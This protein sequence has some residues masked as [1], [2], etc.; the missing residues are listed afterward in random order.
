[1][2]RRE[3][4]PLPLISRR[5]F[6]AASV[7]AGLLGAASIPVIGN[8][9]RASSFVEYEGLEGMASRM[10]VWPWNERLDNDQLRH[11]VADAT[12]IG[13]QHGRRRGLQQAGLTAR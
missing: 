13:L 6:L 1:M 4:P 2:D 12:L 11:R 10:R 3:I 5:R 7:K 8:P 9:A